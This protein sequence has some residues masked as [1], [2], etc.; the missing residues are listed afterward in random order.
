[1]YKVGDLV[2]NGVSRGYLSEVVQAA[3]GIQAFA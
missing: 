1:M 3:A 2:S